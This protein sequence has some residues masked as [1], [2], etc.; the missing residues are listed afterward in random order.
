MYHNVKLPFLL[1]TDAWVLISIL[2]VLMIISIRLGAYLGKHR[3]L[4][5][6]FQDNP[7]NATIYGSI[8]GLSA[9][10][11]AFCF[12]MSSTRYEN[13]H[14]AIITEANALGTAI[15]RADLYPEADRIIMRKHF[16]NYL[17][18]RIDYITAGP[19][20]KK[21][22][23]AEGAQAI[24]QALLWEH[25]VGFSKRNPSVI[26]SGQMLPGLNETF[27]MAEATRNSELIRVPETVVVMLFILSVI[28]AF[29]VGYLS[30]GKGLFDWL[31]G[32][33]FCLLSSLVIFVTLDLDRPR[34]GLIQM[35]ASWYSITSLMN[36][37]EDQ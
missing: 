10:L 19:D 26:I 21:I 28:A 33:G 6:E 17:Q 22:I 29:F 12:S 14:Q 3:R 2:F 4:K 16:K 23:A 34:R 36:M 15:L 8:F 24:H 30:I 20:I 31:T 25:A 1:E 9:F 18:A 13:R 32:V 37:F 11:L 27:D 5:T 35:K 7:A